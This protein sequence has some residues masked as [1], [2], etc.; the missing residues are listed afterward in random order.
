MPAQLTRHK[1]THKREQGTI[2][3]WPKTGQERIDAFR[4]IVTECQYAKIDGAMID[5][6]SANCVVQIYDVLSDMNKEKYAALPA[7]KMALVALKLANRK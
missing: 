7:N 5:L 4:R 6:F 3:C 1:I 2:D